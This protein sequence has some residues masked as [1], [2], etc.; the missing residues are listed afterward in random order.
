MRMNAH[1]WTYKPL[2]DVVRGLWRSDQP[3]AIYP[4][5][6]IQDTGII[7]FFYYWMLQ[8]DK[9]EMTKIIY[10]LVEATEP[11]YDNLLKDTGITPESVAYE[12]FTKIIGFLRLDGIDFKKEFDTLMSTYKPFSDFSQEEVVV[13]ADAIKQKYL[14]LFPKYKGLEKYNCA[15]VQKSY[16]TNTRIFCEK[17]NE[18]LE[19]QKQNV[20]VEYSSEIE[21]FIFHEEESKKHLVKAV[22]LRGKKDIVECDA[23]V[24]CAGSFI[25]KLVKENFGLICPVIPIK[26]YSFD[27]PTDTP[28]HGLHFQFKSEAFVAT[29]I[30]EGVWRIAAFGDV[31]GQDK[32]FDP[33]RVRYLKNLVANLMD[34]DEAHSYVNLNTCLRPTPPDDIPIVGP[35]KFYPNVFL[36]AGHAGRGTTLGLGTSKLVSELLMEGK[37]TVVDDPKPYS[38]RRFQL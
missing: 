5:K 7:K 30:K 23:V 2:K 21:S 10:K 36:N 29:N 17:L 13:G 25:A 1:P 33:R 35:L 22:K 19:T 3:Q 15:F 26:G 38:P 24:L 27:M 14:H 11:L 12:K 34:K 37:A 20:K 18:Y 31:S 4:F 28:S 32:S 16:T 8:G 9:M 6:A